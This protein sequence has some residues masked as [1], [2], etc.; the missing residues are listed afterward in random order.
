MDT[1]EDKK[2][3]IQKQI[4]TLRNVAVQQVQHLNPWIRLPQTFLVFLNPCRQKRDL[5]EIKT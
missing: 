2:V 5:N 1:R 3:F 4:L